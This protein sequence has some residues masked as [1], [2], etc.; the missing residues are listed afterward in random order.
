MNLY[1]NLSKFIIIKTYLFNSQSFKIQ[2]LLKKNSNLVNSCDNLKQTPLHW[3][4]KRGN[5]DIIKLLLD[6]GAERGKFIIYNQ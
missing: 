6:H 1:L 3:A 2:K 5:N 4:A